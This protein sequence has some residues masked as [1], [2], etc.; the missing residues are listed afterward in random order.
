MLAGQSNADAKFL[1][2]EEP[3]FTIAFEELEDMN[4]TTILIV[5]D[6]AIVA[7]DLAAKLRQLGYEVAGIVSK[8]EEA[9]VLADSLRPDLVLMDIQLEGHTDGIEAAE[10]ISSQ[11]DLPIIY[12]TAHSDAATLARAKLSGPFGFILKPFEERELATNIEI[13]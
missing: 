4:K 10:A 5:E 2:T 7:A 8:G 1:Q 11:L 3:E 12:L 9:V 13:S 6:E